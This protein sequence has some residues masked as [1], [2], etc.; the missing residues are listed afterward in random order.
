MNVRDSLNLLHSAVLLCP[1]AHLTVPSPP[2]SR[3][4]FQASQS[5]A[6]GHALSEAKIKFLFLDSHSVL[7]TEMTTFFKASGKAALFCLWNHWPPLPRS[8]PQR[9]HS[10]YTPHLSPNTPCSLH[11]CS[12]GS[13]QPFLPALHPQNHG[14]GALNICGLCRELGGHLL[15]EQGSRVPLDFVNYVCMYGCAAPTSGCTVSVRH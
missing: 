11:T 9:P 15:A 13:F 10:N 4:L 1:P 2:S 3:T 12:R 5:S 14:A 7:F 8:Q 6:L